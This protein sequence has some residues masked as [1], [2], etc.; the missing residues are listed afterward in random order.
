MFYKELT[1][2]LDLSFYVHCLPR[3]HSAPTERDHDSLVTITVIQ[4]SNSF[5]QELKLSVLFLFLFLFCINR[6]LNKQFF[7]EICRSDLY[8]LLRDY[9][10]PF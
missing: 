6:G 3:L 7:W 2:I 10:G 9:V 5:S 8:N 4:E 1:V